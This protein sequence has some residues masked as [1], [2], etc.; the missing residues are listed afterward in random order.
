LGTIGHEL[1]TLEDEGAFISCTLSQSR[2]V[3]DE[4]I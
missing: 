4:E 2:I 1:N 3:A